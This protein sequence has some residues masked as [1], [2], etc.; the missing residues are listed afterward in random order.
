AA[1][2][3]IV[4]PSRLAPLAPQDEV[5][6]TS[7]PHPEVRA[8][9]ASKDASQRKTRASLPARVS[10]YQFSNAWEA[11][12]LSHSAFKSVRSGVLQ[13]F[14]RGLRLG[15]QRGESLRL[16]D[17]H[18]GQHLAVD[19][20]AGLVEAVDEAAVGEAVLAHRCV[21]ALDPQGA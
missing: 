21:D 7:I 18:V 4:R 2:V 16:V 5:C 1:V 13:V 15:D 20:D 17:R 11:P 6:S 8:E 12:V 19:L 10:Q 14:K 3:S 9:R